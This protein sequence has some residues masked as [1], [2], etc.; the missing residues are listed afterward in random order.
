ML[1]DI[2]TSDN[3][4]SDVWADSA[5]RN[6]ANEARLKRQSRISRIHRKKPLGKLARMTPHPVYQSVPSA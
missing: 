1:R 2:V 6:Q 5:Y 4:A 3:T